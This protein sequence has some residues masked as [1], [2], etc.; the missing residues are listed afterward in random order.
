MYEERPIS[1]GCL[2]ARKSGDTKNQGAAGTSE[3][4]FRV[5][6]DILRHMRTLMSNHTWRCTRR[7]R[8]THRGTLSP[9]LDPSPHLEQTGGRRG[10][11][12]DICAEDKEKLQPGRVAPPGGGPVAGQQDSATAVGS[13]REEQV[14]CRA[15]LSHPDKMQA[16]TQASPAAPPH[17]PEALHATSPPATASV[18]P[19]TQPYKEKHILE[20]LGFHIL[21]LIMA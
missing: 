9:E 7:H 3:V 16:P 11:S 21:I 19:L 5:R 6:E 4:R 20:R 18:C 14:A 8:D 2:K 1:T 17:H 15:P 12:S 13:L 10:A